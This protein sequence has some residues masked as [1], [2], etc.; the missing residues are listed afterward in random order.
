MKVSNSKPTPS[1]I[2]CF[3]KKCVKLDISLMVEIFP[4]MNNAPGSI[5]SPANIN[6]RE[7][8]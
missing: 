1:Y 5:S 2:I 7:H 8:S 6:A 3:K 4:G